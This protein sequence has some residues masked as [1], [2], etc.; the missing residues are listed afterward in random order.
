MPLSF[1]QER[2]LVAGGSGIKP[3]TNIVILSGFISQMAGRRQKS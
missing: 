2:K 1:R 3:I